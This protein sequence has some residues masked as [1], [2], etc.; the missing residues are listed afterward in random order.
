MKLILEPR[1]LFDGS[2]VAAVKHAQDGS[3]RA[4]NHAEH[5]NDH[6]ATPASLSHDAPPAAATHALTGHDRDHAVP[7]NPNATEIL[8]VDPRVANWQTLAASVGS[9][10]QVIV[11]DP[12]RDGLAQVTRALEGR[13]GI[14]ALEF[15]TYGSSGQ[16]ELG[17]TNVTADS[18]AAHADE[19]A[20]WRNS[21]ADH[22]NI[23]FW[24]CDVG[25]GSAGTAFLSLMHDLTGVDIGAST[26][27]TGAAELG[28]NWIL[29]ATTGPLLAGVPFSSA[30]LAAYNNVLDPPLTQTFTDNYTFAPGTG[31]LT[32]DLSF[33]KF[34]PSL[35][36]L[37][38]ITIELTGNGHAI[39]NFF[40]F[41]AFAVSY[42]AA[43]ANGDIV[44]SALGL[45]SLLSNVTTGDLAGNAAP[46]A[47]ST[48]GS[49]QSFD[50]SGS[51]GAASFASYT[52]AGNT[53]VHLVVG[54]FN[55]TIIYG[56]PAHPAGTTFVGGDGDVSG[57]VSVIYTY[58]VATMPTPTP[59]PTPTPPT[60][61]IHPPGPVPPPPT[62]PSDPPPRNP[63]EPP[64]P[65]GPGCNADPLP[66]LESAVDHLQDTPGDYPLWLVGSVGDKFVIVEQMMTV[67]IPPQVFQH[68]NPDETL[69][70]EVSRPDGSQLPNWIH[71][72]KDT[73]TL[74]GVPPVSA[75]GDVDVVIKAK[76]Q[77]GNQAEAQFRILVGE[78]VGHPVNDG[79]TAPRN[80]GATPLPRSSEI[81]HPAGDIAA[82][83][84]A[85]DKPM[86]FASLA[87]PAGAEIVRPG[88]EMVRVTRQSDRSHD[89]RSD[90]SSQLRDA[91]RMGQLA[92]ARVFLEALETTTS[93]PPIS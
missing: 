75:H 70:F 86:F 37:Q 76:D 38:S 49:N 6:H 55:A 22:A 91:G 13:T 15:L 25:A 58:Q 44:V 72:D 47:S 8:I 41:N 21:L 51:V 65:P 42:T 10:V 85:G 46:G 7:Q 27:R 59:T 53:T 40:N 29:E 32:Q 14:T 18:L 19:I 31:Q 77:H 12:N 89:G 61:P 50:I 24:G 52:G 63:P 82:S 60:P 45:T 33:Q 93:R 83:E 56:N 80:S 11:I 71:F 39:L 90:F 34:D 57:T 88:A 74:T 64:L 2:V 48:N 62:P 78:E 69:T 66:P 17:R 84:H 5:H 79:N 4:D 1:Y 36:T 54:A 81:G 16:I 26:D 9:N 73:L 68:A 20:S 28:G 30:A 87:Q 23:L 67:P 3:H 43:N 92:R 35:G